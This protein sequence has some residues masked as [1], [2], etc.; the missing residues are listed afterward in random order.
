M[1]P[2]PSDPPVIAEA[3]RIAA[4]FEYSAEDV[5]RAVDEFV[6]E[7]EKG[8]TPEGSTLSQ[9]PSFITSVPDGSEKVSSVE[10][11]C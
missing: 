1:P 6:S 10:W 7:M 2:T 9:I 8:L 4:E 3:K 11:L 5:N